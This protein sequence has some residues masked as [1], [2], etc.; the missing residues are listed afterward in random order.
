[1]GFLSVTRKT[2]VCKNFEKRAPQCVVPRNCAKIFRHLAKTCTWPKNSKKKYAKKKNGNGGKALSVDTVRDLARSVA[3]DVVGRTQ[4][5]K[6]AATYVGDS[7]W[8]FG[9][10]T[11]SSYQMCTKE[12]NI[13]MF[14]DISMEPSFREDAHIP[15]DVGDTVTVDVQYPRGQNGAPTNMGWRRDHADILISAIKLEAQIYGSQTVKEETVTVRLYKSKQAMTQAE[16]NSIYTPYSAGLAVYD[17]KEF[18]YRHKLLKEWEFR[19]NSGAA[20]QHISNINPTT[21]DTTMVYNKKQKRLKWTEGFSPPLK[22]EYSNTLASGY[23]G[24]R[25]HLLVSSGA[26]ASGGTE[27]TRPHIFGVLKTYFTDVE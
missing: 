25:F 8:N 11:I 3:R 2:P 5:K 19:F 26:L 20:Q 15:V 22:F 7:E 16:A 17:K 1:M 9:L 27:A 23:S 13:T 10:E 24:P 4:I 6:W 12:P 18:K 21:G 14:P